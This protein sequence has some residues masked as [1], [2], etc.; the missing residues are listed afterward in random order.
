MTE[1]DLREVTAHQESYGKGYDDGFTAGQEAMRER[2]A[3]ACAA[4]RE[5]PNACTCSG[6]RSGRHH[7]PYCEGWQDGLDYAES[8]IQALEVEP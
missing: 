1:E 7:S 8:T 2:A 6:G 3:D 5:T 4:L